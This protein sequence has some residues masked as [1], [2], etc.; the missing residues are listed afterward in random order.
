MHILS[1]L[2]ITILTT[3]T[4]FKQYTNAIVATFGISRLLQTLKING[5]DVRTTTNSKIHLGGSSNANKL[6]N[7][8]LKYVLHKMGRDLLAGD[9]PAQFPECKRVLLKQRGR[10]CCEIFRQNKN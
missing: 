2:L 6:W 8:D 9:L 7:F 10:T 3:L 5:Q 4:S 1:Q